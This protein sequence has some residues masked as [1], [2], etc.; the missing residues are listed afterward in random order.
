MADDASLSPVAAAAAASRQTRL[1]LP[2]TC[3]PPSGKHPPKQAVWIV[4]PSSVSGQL[5]LGLRLTGT[6]TQVF[7][8]TGHMGRY[9]VRTVLAHG[10]KITAV[11]WTQEHGPE[12]VERGQQRNSLGLTCDVRVRE[13]VDA[14]IKKSVSHWGKVDIIVK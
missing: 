3:E 10:D 12:Q 11:G 14:V 8:A 4:R 1:W 5:D 9:L 13:S 7:G 2:A 6:L